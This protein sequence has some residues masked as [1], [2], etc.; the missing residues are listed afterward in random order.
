M[1]TPLERRFPFLKAEYLTKERRE[2][3]AWRLIIESEEIRSRFSVIVNHTYLG[4]QSNKISV[5]EL[6]KSLSYSLYQDELMKELHD[7]TDLNEAFVKAKKVWSFFDFETVKKIIKSFFIDD[8]DLQVELRSYESYFK[9]YCQRRL[10]DVPIDFLLR[11][12]VPT[13]ITNVHVKVDE[14]F[15]NIQL[16]KVKVIEQ[17]LSHLLGTDLYLLD[18]KDGCKELIFNCFCK[19]NAKFPLKEEDLLEL[20]VLRLYDDTCEYFPASTQAPLRSPSSLPS[21]LSPPSQLLQSA[22]QTTDIPHIPLGKRYN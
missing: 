16:E 4:L 6:K 9:I 15:N 18:V 20:G 8:F 17:K 11:D 10:C 21:P 7:V 1:M 5:D 14:T 3:L 22:T 2:R 13:K 12:E 19:I